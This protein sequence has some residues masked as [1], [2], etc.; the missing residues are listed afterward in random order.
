M[1]EMCGLTG[2]NNPIKD[3][4]TIEQGGVVIGKVC[5]EC[6]G[7]AKGIK[8]FIRREPD[9]TYFSLEE[10]QRIENPI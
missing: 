3:G 4:I 1:E 8:I 7:S 10:I 5:E 9:S 2:C 6:L